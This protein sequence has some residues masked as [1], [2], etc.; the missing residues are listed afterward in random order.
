MN[1]TGNTVLITGGS[2]GIGLELARQLSKRGN[3][4]IVTGRDASRLEAAKR[5][6]P[7]LTV[8]QSNAGRTE[9]IEALYTRVTQ[10]FPNVNVLINNAGIGRILNL[11]EEGRS[12]SDLTQEIDINFRGPVQL[13]YRFLP[14]L[15]TKPHAAIAIV[16]SG[17]AFVP[18]PIMPVYCATKAALHS[19]SLSLRIQLKKTAVKV[20]EFAPP[21]TQ[22][23]FVKS[24][25]AADMEGISTMKV[26]DMVAACVKAMEKDQF[27][28][29]PGQASSLKFMNRLAP[30]FILGQ[31]SKPVD[32]MLSQMS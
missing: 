14:H 26:Q 4:I 30:A 5:E 2:A 19:F 25:N 18:L 7:E 17:L 22:T 23:D 3:T 28:V 24:M 15:K 20:F 27:E 10:E 1:L 12:L 9:D 13:T 31:L 11:H 32:R 29:S 6:L 16:S 8:I 21:T